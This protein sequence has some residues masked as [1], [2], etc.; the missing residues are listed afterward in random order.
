MTKL[1]RKRLALAKQ[2]RLEHIQRV[3]Y[4]TQDKAEM[5]KL[6]SLTNA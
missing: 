1:E 2:K 4:E 5:I 3:K 6:R